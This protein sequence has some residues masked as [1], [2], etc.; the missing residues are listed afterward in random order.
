MKGIPK[1]LCFALFLVHLK[2][3][4]GCTDSVSNIQAEP[5]TSTQ[6][7]K[8]SSGLERGFRVRD[9]HTAKSEA[10]QSAYFVAAELVGPGAN[11]EVAVWLH[12]RTPQDPG[13]LM[14]VDGYAK[15]FSDWPD[16]SKTKA[17]ATMSDKPAQALQQYVES[18]VRG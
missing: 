6:I 11:G 14:S 8:I 17:S 12:L 9:A 16:A 18:R 13:L 10:H 4:I 15:E 3:S 1:L 7:D 5:A 2:F